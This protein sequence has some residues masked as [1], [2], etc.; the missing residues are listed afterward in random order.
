LVA[1]LLVVAVVLLG[2]YWYL[3]RYTHSS[4]SVVDR[5][6]EA[7][8]A[9]IRQQPDDLRLRVA[10]ANL[11]LEKGRYQEAIAQAE[12]V[13]QRAPEN[14]GAL[15]TL[16]Q[17]HS[18]QGNLEAAAGYLARAVE[19]NRENPMA[20]TSLQLA[21]VHQLLGEVYMKQGRA[22]DS[23]AEFRKVLEID[24]TNADALYSLGK[25]LA[26][27]G[28]E[29]EALQSYRQALRLVPDFP[30]VYADLRQIYEARGDLP[31]AGFA[32][33]MVQYASGDLDQAVDLLRAASQA[34]PDAAEVHLGLAMAY[35]KRG[36]K[37]EAV[38]Q[39]RRVASLE[40]DSIAAKQGL[41]RLGGQ[42]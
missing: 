37:A 17:A 38:E 7:V 40:P 2:A 33:G 42:R 19:H 13:L 36:L 25:A 26:A 22:E 39:Y 10:V 24:R 3:Q 18:R 31:R 20:R 29:D 23:A 27:L 35:E 12:Q 32:Q 5:D 34:L 21:L 1:L 6:T 30:E 28:R 16:G 8:E 41:S 4:V 14:L 9:Q 11:Y 15:T